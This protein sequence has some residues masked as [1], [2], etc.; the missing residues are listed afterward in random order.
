MKSANSP[1]P[2]VG[3]HCSRSRT[4]QML[5]F[6]CE[7][8]CP[9]GSR[10][11]DSRPPDLDLAGFPEQINDQHDHLGLDRMFVTN[12]G[13]HQIVRQRIDEQKTYKQKSAALSI[14]NRQP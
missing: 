3:L 14:A 11:P 12:E 1:T 6:L 7:P 10:V 8:S 13:H 2:E 5:N 9:C 4:L